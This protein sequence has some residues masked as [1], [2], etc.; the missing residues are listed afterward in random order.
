MDRDQINQKLSELENQIRK[1]YNN[2]S[3]LD[4]VC[5][6]ESVP[7]EIDHGTYQQ[8]AG[9]YKINRERITNPTNF[10]ILNELGA[11]VARS[12]II[13]LIHELSNSEKSEIDT[14]SIDKIKEKV[15][16]M[17]SQGYH[18]D[19]V[20]I[21][22]EYYDKVFDWNKTHKPFDS[23]GNIVDR[24]YLD[25][26]S[27][28]RIKYSNKK[29]EFE[30]VIIASKNANHWKYRPDA[31]TN[32]RIT[33]KF[34]WDVQDD[35]NSILLVKTVFKFTTDRNGGNVVLKIRDF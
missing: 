29:I 24:L 17:R 26:V 16:S 22:I 32:G 12:E 31:E 25:R 9:R 4:H 18:P 3:I 11:S 20:F 28:L 33:A 23:E 30:D 34:D 1:S 6:L 5:I 35:E 8:F 2:V 10:L 21:P 14:F 7:E 13:F 15:F 19:V 27:N